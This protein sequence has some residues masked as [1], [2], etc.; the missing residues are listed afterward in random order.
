MLFLLDQDIRR[1]YTSYSG[2]GTYL[3][4]IDIKI[5]KMWFLTQ[6]QQ[7]EKRKLLHRNFT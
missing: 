4:S 6:I 2:V 1:G 3:V 5:K 7:I